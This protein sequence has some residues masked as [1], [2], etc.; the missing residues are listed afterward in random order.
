MIPGSVL[1]ELHAIVQRRRRTQVVL[2]AFG[3]HRHILCNEEGYITAWANAWFANSGD[4]AH[5]ADDRC[6]TKPSGL[7]QETKGWKFEGKRPTV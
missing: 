1:G 3:M 6:S 5:A 4:D 2:R 7:T